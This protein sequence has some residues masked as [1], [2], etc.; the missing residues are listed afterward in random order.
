MY[1]CMHVCVCVLCVCVYI[2]IYVGGCVRV[3]IDVASAASRGTCE[4]GEEGVEGLLL[5]VSIS[6]YRSIDR[7]EIR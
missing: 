3:D 6:V 5:Y 1:A 2:Y 7:G 4:P